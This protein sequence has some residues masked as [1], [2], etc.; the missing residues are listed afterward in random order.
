MANWIAQM[1]NEINLIELFT[2]ERAGDFF[3]FDVSENGQLNFAWQKSC[4][5]NKSQICIAKL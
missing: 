3:R 4:E 5:K 2:V 1:A